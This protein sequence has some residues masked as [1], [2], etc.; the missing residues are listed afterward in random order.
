MKKN[1]VTETDTNAFT[2]LANKKN[3][4]MSSILRL[5]LELTQLAVFQR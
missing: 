1:I 2:L 3:K 5:R 4:K